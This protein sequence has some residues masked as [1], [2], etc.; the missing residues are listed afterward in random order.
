MTE[1]GQTNG[2]RLAFVLVFFWI[3]GV[4][5]VC[6]CVDVPGRKLTFT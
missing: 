1:K 2:L 6:E 4:H 5:A 3:V